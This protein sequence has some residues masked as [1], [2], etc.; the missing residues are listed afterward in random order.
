M[1]SI[2]YEVVEVYYKKWYGRNKV[3]KNFVDASRAF[4]LTEEDESNV[5]ESN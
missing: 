1:P 5:L 2:Y 4:E 3:R